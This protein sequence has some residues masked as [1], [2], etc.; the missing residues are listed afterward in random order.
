MRY[1]VVIFCLIALNSVSQNS[2]SPELDS[3]V[4]D[5]INRNI[6]R[7]PFLESCIDHEDF[8]L[9]HF[10]T[11]SE[12]DKIVRTNF[13][14]PDLLDEGI[15]DIKVRFIVNKYGKVENV[16]MVKKSI[17]RDF[18]KSAINAVKK[19]PMFF[20][21]SS[22]GEPVSVVYLIPFRVIVN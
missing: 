3:I 14:I 1:I 13:V 9:R 17:D 20:P 16:E 6:D 7:M 21:G 18:N 2:D 10:C 19:L 12:I 22:E 4:S 8:N 5:S 15:Y 11:M